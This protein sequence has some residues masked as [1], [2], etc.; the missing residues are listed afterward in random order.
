MQAHAKVWFVSVTLMALSGCAG[1]AVDDTGKKPAPRT[2]GSGG[3]PY[4]Y[5]PAGYSGSGQLGKGGTSSIG[6]SGGRTSG[7]GGIG[8]AAGTN[9]PGMAGSGGNAAGTTGGM[10][11]GGSNSTG[12]GGA[13]NPDTTG[14]CPSAAYARL[15]NGACT[16]RIREFEIGAMDPTNIVVGSDGRLWVDDDQGNQIIRMDTDGQASVRVKC[17]EGSS[18]RALLGGKD[19]AL[20]W[21]TDSKAQSL[22]K[23]TK[24]LQKAATPLSFKASAIGLGP[25]S[26]VFLAEFNK[27]VYRVRPS[28]AIPARWDARPSEVALVMT[29]DSNIWISEGSAIAQLNPNKGVVTDF[30]LDEGLFADGLCVGP[31]MGLWFTDALG[32]RLKR[33]SFDGGLSNTINLPTSTTPTR[34]VTG[35]DKALWFIESGTNKIGRYQPGAGGDITHYSIPT[36]GSMPVALVVGP[37]K[38]IWFTENASKKVA[39]LIPDPVQ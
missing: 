8:G 23:V 3:D 32:S 36:P 1:E 26:D 37:D 16:E 2:L 34:I 21:Y 19:D 29:P 7:V 4:A 6:G 31:D 27:A 39:R 12:K 5:P 35:P 24:D 13:E 15:P 14:S 10:G 25:N 30:P 28:Q 17:D 20:F 11:S 33:M 38:N 22:I 18:P 9:P